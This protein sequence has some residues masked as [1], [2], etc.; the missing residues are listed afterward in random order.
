MEAIDK[1][2]N[3]TIYLDAHSILDFFKSLIEI[4]TTEI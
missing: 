4:S 2:M 3:N 1:M